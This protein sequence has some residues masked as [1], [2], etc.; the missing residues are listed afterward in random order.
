[1]LDLKQPTVVWYR[2]E[3]HQ[4]EFGEPSPL[5]V[6]GFGLAYHLVPTNFLGIA[7]L[8]LLVNKDLLGAPILPG[9]P[10]YH[11]FRWENDFHLD[12]QRVPTASMKGLE[13]LEYNR[14]GTPGPNNEPSVEKD[15][16]DPLTATSPPTRS[17]ERRV[18]IVS[19]TR[20]TTA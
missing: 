18:G 4:A 9:V 15:Y 2:A 1:P 14:L 6:H 12:R 8:P 16:F 7:A 11:A 5:C 20:T 17:E 19:S 10:S 3:V 13:G